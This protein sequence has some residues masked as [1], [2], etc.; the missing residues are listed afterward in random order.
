MEDA[1]K[2]Q[3]SDPLQ[4]LLSMPLV[5]RITAVSEDVRKN[6]GEFRKVD[7][8]KLAEALGAPS[9]KRPDSSDWAFTSRS[10]TPNN[11]LNSTPRLR[12]SLSTA[13]PCGSGSEWKPSGWGLLTNTTRTFPSPSP[14]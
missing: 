1:A 8:H 11:W 5:E 13:I 6:T 7:P 4:K 10:S 2:S 3:S 12:K 14:A 9:T